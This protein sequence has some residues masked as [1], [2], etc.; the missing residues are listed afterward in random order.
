MIVVPETHQQGTMTMENIPDNLREY[1][2]I[3]GDI[4]LQVAKDGRIWLCINGI[5]FIRF[6]PHPDGKM[7][8]NLT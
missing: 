2:Y 3:K 5:A 7:Q 6:S 8:A 4:G 1:G